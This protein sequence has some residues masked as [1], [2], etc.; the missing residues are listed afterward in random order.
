VDYAPFL[1][2]PD[3]NIIISIEKGSLTKEELEKT[4]GKKDIRYGY[5]TAHLYETGSIR[6]HDG[7]S[8]EELVKKRLLTISELTGDVYF[9]MGVDRRLYMDMRPPAEVYKEIKDFPPPEKIN[10]GFKKEM[11]LAYRKLFREVMKVDSNELNNLGPEKALEYLDNKYE[12]AGVEQN[13]TETIRF[14]LELI[15]KA[16][17][18]NRYDQIAVII[19]LLDIAGYFKDKENSK[20]DYARMWDSNHAYYAS[21]SDIFLSDDMRARKKTGIAY[22]LLGLTTKIMA[23]KDKGI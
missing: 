7:F 5:S 22:F 20:T 2:Y 3:N 19:G 23:S 9:R 14:C 21:Y 13:F 18:V 15:G 1:V 8:K 4:L 16:G 12:Q 17:K 10:E 11:P 6:A